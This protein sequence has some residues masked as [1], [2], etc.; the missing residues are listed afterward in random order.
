MSDNI[1]LDG[2]NPFFQKF[3]EKDWFLDQFKQAGIKSLTATDIKNEKGVSI[4][5]CKNWVNKDLTNFKKY[6]TH[7][8]NQLDGRD[9]FVKMF[10]ERVNLINK[11]K[12][13]PI[14]SDA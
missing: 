3:N 13:L 14:L 5:S 10:I 4:E 11:R 8:S 9:A 2:G 12:G 7:Y 1:E 6:L